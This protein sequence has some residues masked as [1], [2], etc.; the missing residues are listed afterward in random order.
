MLEHKGENKRVAK[1]MIILYGRM[2]LLLVVSLFTSRVVLAGLGVEDYGIYNVVGG[3]VAMFGFINLALANSTSR[4]IT[5]SLGK[6]NVENSR[7]VFSSV[8]MAHLIIAVIIVILSETVG[9]WFLNNKMV[10][11]ES[12]ITAA[13]WVYQFSVIS[14]IASILYTPFNATIIAHEKMSAFAY[15]SILDAVLKLVIAYLITVTSS[16]KLI[17]YAFL[18]LCVNTLNIIIYQ[19]YCRKH[20]PEVKLQRVREISTLKEIL[21]FTGWSMVGN[22]AFVG[23]TQG[24][25]ILLNLF[26]G[27]I[28]NAAR[29]IATQLQGA[30]IGFVTNFQ[31]A[32]NPQI[33]KSYAIGDLDRM[34][35]LIYTSS[36]FSFFLLFVI[37]LPLC[38]ES[39]AILQ[40]WLVD[41]PDYAVQFTILTLLTKL[42]DTLSNPMGIANNAT[43]QIRKYQL[44]E[45]G[46]LL[47]IV[48][49][50]YFVLTKGADPLSVFWVQLIIMYLVQILRLYLVC[51]KIKMSKAEY[52]RKVVFRILPVCVLSPIIPMGLHLYLNQ[53]F[54]TSVLVMCVAVICSCISVYLFG[55]EKGERIEVN[56][57]F[58]KFLNKLKAQSA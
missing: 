40:V 22:L 55:L 2:I 42:I 25:N 37:V 33:T 56:N 4:F 31:M 1:N 48:P 35:Q 52:C 14:C 9:L 8:F 36:K 15:I 13:S 11:P 44:C 50:S 49:I 38:I 7:L 12:R 30:V 54:W 46:T 57:I 29:A 3:I 18:Y 24:I 43:G 26:F 53:N 21:G 39:K 20:F 16:D 47:L 32:V 58:M 17:L 5:Y 19:S 27:P 51:D 28:V 45:G 23:Y 10:I 34:H 6:G 41:V